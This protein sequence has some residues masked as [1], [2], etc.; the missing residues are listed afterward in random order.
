MPTSLIV[1]RSSTSVR[2]DTRCSPS[3]CEHGGLC[4]QSWTVFHCNCSDSGYSGATCHSSVYE[5]SC[6]AYKHNGNT[7]GHF[8]IDVDGSGPIKPQL[9][10]CN[11]TEE[12]TWM[13]IQHNNTELTRVR[14]SSGLNPHSVHFD[15]PTEEEQLLAVI[16][17]SEHCEQE[18]SY[19]CRKSRLLNTPVLP[20]LHVFLYTTFLSNKGEQADYL[21]RVKLRVGVNGQEVSWFK[22]YLFQKLPWIEC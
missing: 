21:K 2:S 18:L 22:E 9:V 19:H 4:S 8:Y 14:P 11:M 1:Y 5:Q 16:S 6:E 3:R 20:V 7:S 17:Q 10:Y 13:V 12:N 15:Y